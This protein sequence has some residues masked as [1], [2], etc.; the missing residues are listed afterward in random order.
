MPAEPILNRKDSLINAGAEDM[1]GMC[2]VTAM[3]AL[4]CIGL[5]CRHAFHAD[6]VYRRLKDGHKTKRITFDFLDCPICKQSI[7]FNNNGPYQLED[8]LAA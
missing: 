8:I 6:C 3:S 1:C 2:H 4:P 7:D 5:R